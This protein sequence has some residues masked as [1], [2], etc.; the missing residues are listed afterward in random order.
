MPPAKKHGAKAFQIE[1]AEHYYQPWTMAW[2]GMCVRMWWFW[3]VRRCHPYFMR[4]NLA[5]LAKP[6]GLLFGGWTLKACDV[7]VA[8]NLNTKDLLDLLE[9]RILALHVPGFVDPETSAQVTEWI[10]AKKEKASLEILQGKES[11]VTL[12]FGLSRRMARNEAAVRRYFDTA[13]S[14]M[15]VLR[16]QCLEWGM[17]NPI[18]KLRLELDECYPDGCVVDQER[19]RKL[20]AGLSRVNYANAKS[21]DGRLHIDSFPITSPDVGLFSA[22]IYLQQCDEGGA[23]HMW[24]VNLSSWWRGLANLDVLR[25]F[26]GPRKG[27]TV[28]DNQAALSAALPAPVVV[29]PEAGDLI[30]LHNGRPHRVERVMEGTRASLQ[31]FLKYV[32]SDPLKIQS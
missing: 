27:E 6:L 26:N 1:P 22:N 18:D 20:F 21:K 24:P 13:V 10:L 3:I 14:E 8:D 19:G 28:N 17:M 9:G 12:G 16:N 30:M 23:L 11:D 2:V 7:R 31:F 29:R 32:R 25:R 4:T 5:V 15:R